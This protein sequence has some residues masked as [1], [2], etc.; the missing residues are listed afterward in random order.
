MDARSRERVN[1]LIATEEVA[2]VDERRERAERKW[3]SDGDKQRKSQA[4]EGRSRLH[5]ERASR[6]SKMQLK[7]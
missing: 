2:D 6:H 1:G 5:R 7:V 4:N 3:S